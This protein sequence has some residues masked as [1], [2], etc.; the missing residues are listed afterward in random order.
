VFAVTDDECKAAVAVLEGDAKKPEE[1]SAA[2]WVGKCW[3]IITS[4]LHDEVY[5]KVNHVSRGLIKS[6]LSEIAH[7][8][9]NNLEEVQP[10]RLELYGASMQKDCGSDLQTWINYIIERAN[11][12]LFLKKEVPQEELVAIF[13][14]GLHPV[15]FQQLQ[16]FFA[17]PGQLPKTFESAVATTRKFA[18]SPAVAMELA[19]LKSTGLSQ[20]MFPMIGE[21]TSSARC[22][23]FASSGQCRYGDQCKFK[24]VAVPNSTVSASGQSVTCNYC[25]KLNHT[26]NVCRKKQRDLAQTATALTSLSTPFA[27]P[28]EAV[29]TPTMEAEQVFTSN[30]FHFVFTVN[31]ASTESSHSLQFSSTARDQHNEEGNKAYARLPPS[32]ALEDRWKHSKKGMLDSSTVWVLDSGATCCA[33]NDETDC[34]DVRDCCVNV[35][36]AGSCFQV[37]RVGTAVINT[38]DKLGRPTQL[39]MQNTLISPSF[40]YKLLALQLLTRKDWQVIMGKDL[41]Q[42]SHPSKDRVFEGSKDP[43]TQL[44]LLKQC[45]LS[46]SP[47]SH[48]Y[49]E[50]KSDLVSNLQRYRKHLVLH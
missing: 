17:I 10:L 25:K 30:Q 48:A 19:K 35:T 12:L 20:S 21:P 32:S 33:T 24:H 28:P 6:L 16:V 50:G 18:S 23:L 42:I 46:G 44:F 4:S 40:P 26:E 11:K 3:T 38:L 31:S 49:G 14:K 2:D 27:L 41:L 37:K 29:P 1:K 7:A 13:L 9:V 15:P 5:L 36:S 34:V 47:L 39:L 45:K 8:I 43:S 22:R